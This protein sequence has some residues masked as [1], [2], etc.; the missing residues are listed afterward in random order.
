[1]KV[2]S[3]VFGFVL[4]GNAWAHD[5]QEHTHWWLGIADA[6][7]TWSAGATV[8]SSSFEDWSFTRRVGPYTS[9]KWDNSDE[10]YRLYGRLDF[11]KYVG[12][13]LGYADLGEV[14]FRGQGDGSPGGFWNAGPVAE[15]L[16]TEAFDLT[17]TG[18]LDLGVDT[19][20][21]ARVGAL[22]WK[23][24]E[25]ISGSS[26]G[27]GPFTQSDSDDGIDIQYG[28]AAEYSGVR[29]LRVSLGYSRARLEAS[30]QTHDTVRLSSFWMSLA[31][32]F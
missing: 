2:W 8:T 12:L 15:S 23:L 19:A 4:C 14:S 7:L 25:S 20:L 31:Y 26:Q 3:A 10:G 18:R 21:T 5:G 28:V 6:D 1:M 16:S 30:T 22:Q 24:E 13:E 32:L 11:L 27:F 9:A 29:P 17:L